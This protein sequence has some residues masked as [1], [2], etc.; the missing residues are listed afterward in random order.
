[1]VN[2]AFSLTAKT[3]GTQAAGVVKGQGGGEII[4]DNVLL[5]NSLEKDDLVVTE[6]NI[7]LDGSGFP[8]DLVVGKIAAVSKNPSDLFQEAKVQSQLDFT[9]LGKVFVVTQ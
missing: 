2:P 6:G 4:L 5:S 3:L 7:N 1:M 8:A 9:K